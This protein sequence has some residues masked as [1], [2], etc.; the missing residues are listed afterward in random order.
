MTLMHLYVANLTEDISE[1]DL[2]NVFADFGEVATV[3]IVK[4]SGNYFAYV[5]MSNNE[6]AMAA[7][8]SLNGKDL[9]G[10]KLEITEAPTF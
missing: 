3:S 9:N 6:E 10:C 7:M 1:S 5:V 4:D 2:E 8:K